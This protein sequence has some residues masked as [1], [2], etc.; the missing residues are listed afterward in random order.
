LNDAEW[1]DRIE[2]SRKELE[3]SALRNGA[4]ERLQ[5]DSI[6]LFQPEERRKSGEP[7]VNGPVSIERIE[8]D[9]PNI[10]FTASSRIA[11]NRGGMLVL[12][13]ETHPA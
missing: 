2:T 11:L 7:S 6:E 12:G 1:I 10:S 9:T 4:G 5:R 8:I 13:L 3:R